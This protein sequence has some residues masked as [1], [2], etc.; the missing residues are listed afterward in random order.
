MDDAE[1][2]VDGILQRAS[3]RQAAA[4]VHA[5]AVVHRLRSSAMEEDS[6]RKVV[7]G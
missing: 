6:A 4:G 5:V 1:V 3:C 2:A 7:D